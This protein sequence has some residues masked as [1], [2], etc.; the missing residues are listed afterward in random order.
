MTGRTGTRACSGMLEPRD[1]HAGGDARPR[2][3]AIALAVG[4]RDA[5][6][7]LAVDAQPATRAPRRAARALERARAARRRACAGRPSGRRRRRARAGP[8]AR[9]PARAR[10]ACARPQPLD[11]QAELAPEREQAVERLGLVAVARDDQRARA[12]SRVHARRL[13]QLGAEGRVA[14]ARSRS[15][16]ASSA[17]SPNSASETGASM[18]AATCHAPGSPASSTIDAQRRAAA[19][20]PRAREADRAAADDGDVE[21]L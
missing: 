2:R 7:A 18:P 8:S 12:R 5:G 14:R 19:A 17:R 20:A 10:R 3:R 11:R 16:S 1:S 4:E 21:A 6:H 9:A 15:P 13:G